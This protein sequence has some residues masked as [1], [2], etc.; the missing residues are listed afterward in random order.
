MNTEDTEW[1]LEIKHK[2]SALRLACEEFESD[3]SCSSFDI[4]DARAYFEAIKEIV[5]KL[6]QLL[7]E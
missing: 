7:A 3:V 4:D 5:D 1:I 2:A 6:N